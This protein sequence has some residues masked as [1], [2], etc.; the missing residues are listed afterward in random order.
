L[1]Q[2]TLLRIDK[3]FRIVLVGAGNLGWHLAHILNNNGAKITCIASR[4]VYSARTLALEVDSPYT[5]KFNE[6]SAEADFIILTV[7]D[8]AL[9]EVIGI[10]PESDAIVLHTSGSIDLKVFEKGYANYGVMY[11]FQ[12]F[13]YGMPVKNTGF[14][15]CIEGSDR[16]TE[17]KIHQLA[18]MISKNVIILDSEKRRLLHLS[19]VLA[20]NF[21]NFLIARAGDLLINSNLDPK[22]LTPLLLETIYKIE[23]SSPQA[24]QTGPAKRKSI[25]IIQKHLEMLNDDPSLKNLYS[26]LSD[27][28]IAY[29]SK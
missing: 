8:S 23:S 26:F 14:P 11:P 4:S 21:S 17:E 12:T 9:P 24:A 28:I 20:N 13:T 15:V 22:L 1:N 2:A 18:M 7:N 6:I 27:S 16:K 29:Y 5:D 19:G 25:N 10:L 3:H